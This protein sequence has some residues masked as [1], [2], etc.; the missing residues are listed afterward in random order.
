MKEYRVQVFHNNTSDNT[1]FDNRDQAIIFGT[2]QLC[3]QSTIAVFLLKH[4]IDGQY[5]MEMQ[6]Q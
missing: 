4:I 3:K 6:I 5:D 1:Y 2:K